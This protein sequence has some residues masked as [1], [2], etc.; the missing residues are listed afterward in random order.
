MSLRR[1]LF[2]VVALSAV[3]AAR[4]SSACDSCILPAATLPRFTTACQQVSGRTDS[5]CTSDFYAIDLALNDMVVFTLCDWTCT[6]A[7][8]NFDAK[9][10]VYDAACNLVAEMDDY[11]GTLPEFEDVREIQRTLKSRGLTLDAEAD[12][13]TAGPAF[14]MLTDPDG[15]PILVDQHV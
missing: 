5:S 7:A 9:L 12:E 8:A 6:S 14:L 3:L 10:R 4:P 15:N 11:C 1:V 2:A 13:T